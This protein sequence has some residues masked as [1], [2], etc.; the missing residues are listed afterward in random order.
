MQLAFRTARTFWLKK[1]AKWSAVRPAPAPAG[2]SLLVSRFLPTRELTTNRITLQ[3]ITSAKTRAT[4]KR[5]QQ[6]IP[7][8]VVCHAKKRPCILKNLVK[9]GIADP[10]CTHWQAP[11]AD[12][13]TK[14]CQRVQFLPAHT[15]ILKC[16]L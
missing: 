9:I 11:R 12:A 10:H 16:K 3:R 4:P 1:N 7:P 8:N 15:G 6:H 2:D 14:A 13:Q 5:R